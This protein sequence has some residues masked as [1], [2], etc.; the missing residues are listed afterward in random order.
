MALFSFNSLGQVQAEAVTFNFTS[1]GFSPEGIPTGTQIPEGIS[2][3]YFF[4]VSLL[5]SVLPLI[6][7]FSFKNFRLQRNLC[8]IETMLLSCVIII[9][10]VLGYQTIDG[11]QVAW[12][13]MVCAPF[14]SMIA[15]IMAY[16]RI[17][18][19][20]RKIAD[21]MRLR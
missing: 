11:A 2:T 14:I 3:W 20:H 4:A 16:Q 15:V 21:S 9:G 7:I 19:D 1:M 10:A 18:A 12:S 17:V 13:A 5:T 6:A 8:L